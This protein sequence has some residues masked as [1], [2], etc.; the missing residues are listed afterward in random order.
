MGLRFQRRIK[1]APGVTVNLSKSGIGASVG[2]RGARY[3][4][5][6]KGQTYKSVG[7]PGTG[8]S[9]RTVEPASPQPGPLQRLVL[10]VNRLFS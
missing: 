8:L 1:I 2:V 9:Y 5:N 3:G 6:P 4:V 7:L 10:W